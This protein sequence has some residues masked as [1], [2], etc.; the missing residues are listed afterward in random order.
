[1][2]PSV[3]T[4][5]TPTL[6]NPNSNSEEVNPFLFP[7]CAVTRAQNRSNKTKA[8][9]SP[10]PFPSMEE[11]C[12]KTISKEELIKA[13]QADASLEKLFHSVI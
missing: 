1:M 13:Q 6:P 7:V 12:N 9:S 3:Q 2:F 11:L 4:V 10:T 5:D 8:V